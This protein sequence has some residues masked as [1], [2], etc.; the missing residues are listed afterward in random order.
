MH[1]GHLLLC[2]SLH[3]CACSATGAERHHTILRQYSSTAMHANVECTADR[4]GR[5]LGL[6][7]VSGL[8]VCVCWVLFGLS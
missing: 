1:T 5:G 3:R 7:S 8:N 6:L 4:P 2:L